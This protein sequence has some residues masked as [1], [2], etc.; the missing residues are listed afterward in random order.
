MEET[1]TGVASSVPAITNPRWLAPEVLNGQKHTLASVSCIAYMH[2]EA[3][4]QIYQ[5]LPGTGCAVQS[6]AGRPGN[7]AMA[8]HLVC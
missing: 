1:G 7:P 2:E 4:Q 6:L 3:R 8:L 5:L